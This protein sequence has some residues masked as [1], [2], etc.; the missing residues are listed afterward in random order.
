MMLYFH[1]KIFSYG[2]YLSF[3][4]FYDISTKSNPY[5]A[6]DVIIKVFLK[7]VFLLFDR[8]KITS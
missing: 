7:V 6:D 4:V 8:H 3:T 1:S 5:Q 2:G